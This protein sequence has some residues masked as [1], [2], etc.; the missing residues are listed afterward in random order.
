[1]IMSTYS[2]NAELVLIVVD[3]T[4]LLVNHITSTGSSQYTV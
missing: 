1:M 2:K 3:M 4:P